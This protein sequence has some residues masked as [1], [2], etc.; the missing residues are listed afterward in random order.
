MR[1]CLTAPGPYLYDIAQ[2]SW[3]ALASQGSLGVGLGGIKSAESCIDKLT[4]FIPSRLATRG[5]G[6][7]EAGMVPASDRRC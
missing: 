3:V 7:Y 2:R 4:E 5:G 6:A 1:R